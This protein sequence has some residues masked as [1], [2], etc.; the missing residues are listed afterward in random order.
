MGPILCGSLSDESIGGYLEDYSREHLS[1][2]HPDGLVRAAVLIPLICQDGVWSLLFTRRT[3]RVE[4]HKGQVS[5]P[6]G[7]AEAVDRSPVDTALREAF[8]ETGL[9]PEQ[10]KVLGSLPEMNTVTGFLVTPVAGRLLEWPL[11]LIPQPHEVSRIFSIPLGW[12]ADRSNWS[13]KPFRRSNGV[14][15]KVIFFEEY[16]GEVLWGATAWMT[17]RFLEALKLI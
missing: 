3:D 6:G 5:F 16:D 9:P 7:A 12:L 2:T 4:T 10:V 14:V 13:E 1:R 11:A 8:E 17:L 15:E